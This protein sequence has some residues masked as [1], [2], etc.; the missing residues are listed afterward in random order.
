MRL[1]QTLKKHTD[2][3]TVNIFLNNGYIHNTYIQVYSSIDV[4]FGV[5]IHLR[6]VTL[7]STAGE[8]ERTWDNTP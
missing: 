1:P 4:L 8:N 2:F 7:Q 6:L 3:V 5:S